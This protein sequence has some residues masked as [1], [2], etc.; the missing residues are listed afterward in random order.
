MR[1][2]LTGVGIRL[3]ARL[4]PGAS[5]S[6][7]ASCREHT[8]QAAH[9]QSEGDYTAVV[10]ILGGVP[11]GPTATVCSKCA[12]NDPSSVTTVHLSGSVRMSAPP[13]FTMGSIA[14][15]MPATNRGPRLGFP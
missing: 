6:I 12:D 14:I 1:T 2:E 3:P 10:R 9:C 5:C 13:A 7:A 8:A 4:Q 15:V 11:S